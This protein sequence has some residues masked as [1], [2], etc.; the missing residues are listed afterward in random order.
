MFGLTAGERAVS[1]AEGALIICAFAYFF[2]CSPIAIPFLLPLMVFVTKQ[3]MKSSEMRKRDQFR[4]QFRDAVMAVSTNQKA[5]YSVEN[6]FREAYSDMSM[7]YGNG[8]PICSELRKINTGLSDHILLEDML[9]KLGQKSGIDD[10]VQFAD[11]F[12]IARRSGGNMTRII[13]STAE[14]IDGR[15]EV[16]KDIHLMLA[17]RRYEQKLME[18]MPFFL[19]IYMKISNKGFFDVLYHNPTGIVIMTVCMLVYLAACAMSE[20]IVTVLV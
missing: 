18:G 4:L 3:C 6:S 7:L 13:S 16:E 17:S 1:L 9:M 5:G 20:K 14:M 2:Y 11:I 19:I 8:S 15:T 12:G 10:I